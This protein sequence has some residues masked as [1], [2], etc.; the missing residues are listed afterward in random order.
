VATV[1]DPE[2]AD[3]APAVTRTLLR[4]GAIT[5]TGGDELAAHLP[6]AVVRVLA[7]RRSA[8]AVWEERR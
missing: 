6:P 8:V 7:D 2:I 4:W 1:P 3:L 5:P